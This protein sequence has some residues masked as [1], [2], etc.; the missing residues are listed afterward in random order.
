MLL[1]SWHLEQLARS[2][3]VDRVGNAQG[4]RGSRGPP[5]KINPKIPL[6]WGP[7]TV[8]CPWTPEVLATPLL[9]SL[10]KNLV[11]ISEKKIEIEIRN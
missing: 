11:I 8:P 2:K 3:R 7:L 6:V 9:K 1:N 5:T 4:P 10:T